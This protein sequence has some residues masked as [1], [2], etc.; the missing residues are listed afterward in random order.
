M[1]GELYQPSQ[2]AQRQTP[3]AVGATRAQP[4]SACI[5]FKSAQAVRTVGLRA[6]LPIGVAAQNEIRADGAEKVTP[7]KGRLLGKTQS[8]S[9]TQQAAETIW[10]AS[11]TERH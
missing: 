1:Q 11:A 8:G 10:S 2:E 3:E 7:E 6:T 9:S 4:P 5:L